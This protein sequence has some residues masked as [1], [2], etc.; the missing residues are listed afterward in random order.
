MPDDLD[1]PKPAETP[2][3][4]WEFINWRIRDIFYVIGATFLSA[5]IQYIFL[6]NI[7]KLSEG[8]AFAFFFVSL[9]AT[10]AFFAWVFGVIRIRGKMSD[11][12]LSLA[13]WKPQ[14]K[15]ALKWLPITI[16]TDIAGLLLII[17]LIAIYAFVV[18]AS[19][20]GLYDQWTKD[21]GKPNDSDITKPFREAPFTYFMAFAV[22]VV[23]APICEEIFFRG[24]VYGA[25]RRRLRKTTAQFISAGFFGI[26]HGFLCFPQFFAGLIFAHVYESNQPKSLVTSITLHALNNS[27]VFILLA[28]AN[29]I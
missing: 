28:L 27:M 19:F 16:L 29:N 13:D 14:A 5:I 25:L 4:Y 6:Y 3:Q 1:N 21:D 9:L 12:G 17:A 7:L 23:V 26:C 10:C 15:R 20:S 18:G 22:L 8:R 11:L 2:S 24:L